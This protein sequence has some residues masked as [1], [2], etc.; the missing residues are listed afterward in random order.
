MSKEQK[1]KE[2]ADIR[3]AMR[4][5]KPLVGHLG[6]QYL[7]WERKYQELKQKA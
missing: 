4:L 1:K 3:R 2:L 5:A 7:Y 6:N